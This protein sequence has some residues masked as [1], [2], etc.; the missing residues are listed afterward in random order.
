[1]PTLFTPETLAKTVVVPGVCAV[2]TP[3]VI[4]VL[5]VAVP[6]H[7]A[8]PLLKVAVVG[9]MVAPYP[10]EVMVNCVPLAM[11]FEPVNATVAVA[12]VTPLKPER[13]QVW[14]FE[15]LMVPPEVYVGVAVLEE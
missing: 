9:A 5:T 6:L 10:G 7:V 4:A 11:V 13:S 3:A 12:F 8:V 14:P 15:P 2:S 1:M